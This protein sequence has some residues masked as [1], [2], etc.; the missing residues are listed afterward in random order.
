[1]GSMVTMAIYWDL[2]LGPA[3]ALSHHVNLSVEWMLVGSDIPPH[4]SSVLFVA[5]IYIYEF[6]LLQLFSFNGYPTKDRQS[7]IEVTHCF[8]Q[9]L[10]QSFCATHSSLWRSITSMLV[11]FM[12]CNILFLMWF[13]CQGITRPE[14]GARGWEEGP[15]DH[16]LHL[17]LV[18]LI[19]C[20][21]FMAL[22]LIFFRLSFNPNSS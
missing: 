17:R 8:L 9:T 14:I 18:S 3:Q 13:C 12:I 20:F 6:Y 5:T 1:M 16:H 19:Q 7:F 10:H 4:C 21:W 15:C 11:I 2:H 22:T